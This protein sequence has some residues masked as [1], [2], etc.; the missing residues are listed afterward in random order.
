MSIITLGIYDVY[1]TFS[2]RNELVKK[3]YYIPS[4]WLIYTPLL[5]LIVVALLQLVA[6]FVLSTVQGGSS[7]AALNIISVIIGVASVVGIIPMALYW[8]WKYCKAVES[9]TGGALSA[10]FNFAIWLIL[11]LVGAWFV[12]PAIVQNYFNKIS[13]STGTEPTSV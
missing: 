12:W 2:T 10:G 6:H 8:A 7:P 5:G 3:G 11:G 13:S 4:P 9:L 1:W